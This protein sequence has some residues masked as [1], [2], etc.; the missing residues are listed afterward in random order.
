MKSLYQTIICTFCIVLLL[1]SCTDTIDVDVPNGGDR[2]VI[3]ASINWE[4]G[5]SGQDQVIKLSKST[6]FF[7][8][9]NQVPVTG[10]SVVVINE[11]NGAVFDFMDQNNGDYTTNNFEPIIEAAYRLEINY[12][13]NT[14]VANETMMSVTPIDYVDQDIESG[15]GDDE[16]V[17]MAHYTDPDVLGNYYLAEFIASNNPLV[18]LE[19]SD[20]EFYNGN[21]T[22]VEYENENLAT[23]DVVNVNLYGV[24]ERF[25]DYIDLLISQSGDGEGP[26][27]TT[28]APLKGNCKNI[29]DPNEEVLGYFRL[30][31][32]S[33]ISY[34]VE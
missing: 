19:A 1:S 20:D 29:N 7:S 5:T 15:F 32:V 34:T 13:G 30:S 17:I 21:Q 26:F 24:S 22:F 31:E 3:E 28:P 2:L 11:D 16:I 23:G 25:Y 12:N 27:Q 10:A 6:P 9:N 33:K 14:Y 8:A 18:G 4:Q